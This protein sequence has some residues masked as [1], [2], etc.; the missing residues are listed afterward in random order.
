MKAKT[1]P[2]IHGTNRS[3]YVTRAAGWEFLKDWV[4]SLRIK[5]EE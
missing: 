4:F 5:G 2:M 3:G 1:D